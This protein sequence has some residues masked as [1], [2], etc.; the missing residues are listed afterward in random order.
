[1]KKSII[2]AALF[3]ATTIG[4][5]AQ[6]Q[7]APVKEGMKEMRH[8]VKQKRQDKRERKEAL[9]TGN[10]AAAQAEKKEIRSDKK[11]INADRKDLKAQGVKHPEKKAKKQIRRKK[12]LVK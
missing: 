6:T 10:Q 1:M 8:D 7:P 9:A 12:Q 4:M 5:N 3:L 2:V 11:E